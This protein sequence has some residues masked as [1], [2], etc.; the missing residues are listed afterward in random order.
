MGG[1]LQAEVWVGSRG[2]R[3]TEADAEGFVRLVQECYPNEGGTD[4][5]L[6]GTPIPPRKRNHNLRDAVASMGGGGS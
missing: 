2:L 3:D 1:G 5:K 6:V 4:L